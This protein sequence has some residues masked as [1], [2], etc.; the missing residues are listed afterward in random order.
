M[1]MTRQVGGRSVALLF[2]PSLLLL[3]ACGGGDG[4]QPVTPSS[5][6]P[7]ASASTPPTSSAAPASPASDAFAIP[8]EPRD[9]KRAQHTTGPVKLDAWKKASAAKGIGAP[10]AACAA[11]VKRTAAT[12]APSDM[13]A[14]LA[15]KDVAKR[16]AMLVA[17]EKTETVPGLT[18]AVRAELA[19]VA[20][21]DG[22]T[23]P[24]LTSK[25]ATS[26]AG[27]RLV[28][29][30][31]AA[32]LA[33]TAEKA[34]TMPDG[35]PAKD[36]TAEKER[37][38]KFIQGPLRTWMVEQAAAIEALSAP[39]AEL[40]GRARGLVALEAG[41]ADLRLVDKIRSAPTPKSWDAELKAV[42]EA[43]LDEALEP[44]KTRG[45]DATLVG[46][47]DFAADGVMFDERVTNARNLLSKLYGGRRIDA[48]DA[49][50]VPA[51]DP[52]PDV[53][54]GVQ[55][56]IG[57]TL[58]EPASPAVARLHRGRLYWRRVDFVEAAHAAKA[59][60]A[61]EDRLV[62]A[63]A[64]ALAKGPNG[65]KEMM[66]AASPAA[67][68]LTHTEALDAIVA[69]GGKTAGMAAYNAALIR[70]LAPPDG[71]AA[72]AHFADVATRFEK[73][74]TLL[75]DP[76]AKA[77]AKARASDARAAAKTA[78]VPEKKP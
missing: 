70:S 64:L 62:L 27:E 71:P 47:S 72:A 33:R 23:D 51:S 26:D 13:T 75:E 66:S 57:G 44:R 30:S 24:I 42:Y 6:K 14:A 16:D 20:C 41:M 34:P 19:P 60:K 76:S 18:R 8:S 35:P 78:V 56:L 3:A 46:L 7:E 45:R 69:E 1:R 29:L 63:T 55:T 4:A 67:L 12:P 43:A 59:S 52:Q 53:P 48:L 39:A 77:Q 22:L 5:P 25:G 74:E 36:A 28:G 2:F 9:T 11:F 32:K 37:V 61:P 65:A 50:L 49:L 38:K 10:P 15:E 17:L 58:K 73:A 54:E 31:L 21:A 40:S 68:G